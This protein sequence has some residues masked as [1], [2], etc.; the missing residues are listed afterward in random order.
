M[1]V[2]RQGVSPIMM[3]AASLLCTVGITVAQVP[4]A[5]SR[6][7]AAYA[8]SV[9][10][11]ATVATLADL[12]VFRTVHVDGVANA[13]N[14]EFRAMTGYLER[15]AGE[16]GLDFADH[17]EVVVIGLGQSESRL[18]LPW[19]LKLL[20]PPMPSLY[21]WSSVDRISL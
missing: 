7:I 18:G 20:P 16:L 9:Y 5:A 4:S 3:A 13:S 14:P 1:P 21:P 6:D 17:G 15:K 10:F 11:E 12:V 19:K 2:S 8:D